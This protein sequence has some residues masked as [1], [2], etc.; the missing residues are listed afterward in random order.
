M[1]SVFF[2]ECGYRIE[3]VMGEVVYNYDLPPSILH[4]ANLLY[5][6]R[7]YV[8][9]SAMEQLRELG[10]PPTGSQLELYTDSRL[11]EEL[12]GDIKTDGK[13][14]TDS[15]AYYIMQ[16]MPRFKRIVVCKCAPTTIK[17]KLSESAVANKI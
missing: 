17:R 13:Y 3:G 10:D 12:N 16:D 15:R 5:A 9:N 6:F 7:W 8:F 11:V 1:I 4:D 2:N 14:A